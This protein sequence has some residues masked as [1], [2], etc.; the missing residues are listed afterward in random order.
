M[1]KAK[2]CNFL[3]LQV[4]VTTQILHR[5]SGLTQ[6]VVEHEINTV[7]RTH[8]LGSTGYPFENPLFP[9]QGDNHNRKN[10]ELSD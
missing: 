9:G 1:R 3:P 10:N 8:L 2:V 5:W 6:E 7:P 4:S